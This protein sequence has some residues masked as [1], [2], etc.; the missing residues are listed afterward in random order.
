M[1]CWKKWITIKILFYHTKSTT[2]FSRWKNL[3][4]NYLLITTINLK[5]AST[6]FTTRVILV[7][8]YWHPLSALPGIFRRK[9]E[10]RPSAILIVYSRLSDLIITINSSIIIPKMPKYWTTHIQ[11]WFYRLLGK[12]AYAKYHSI[13]DLH[14]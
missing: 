7:L 1:R 2:P 14:F 3:V 11:R 9:Y 4:S 8:Y 10:W 6:F 5:K 13:P 12:R